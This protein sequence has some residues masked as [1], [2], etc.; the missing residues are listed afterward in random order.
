MELATKV[1]IFAGCQALM[2]FM[3][4][5]AYNNIRLNK[6]AYLVREALVA[7]EDSAWRRLLHSRDDGSLRL[8]T[9]L[10]FAS[11]ERLYADLF[12]FEE[13]ASEL[14]RRN[15]RRSL[16]TL[17]DKLGV[18]LFYIGSRMTESEI[19]M[20]FGVLQCTVSQALRYV[21]P[22]VS[23]R[24]VDNPMARIA[25]PTEA[26]MHDYAEMVMQR[27][28][29]AEDVMGFLD[30]CAMPIHCSW[31][32]NPSYHSDY[33]GT[34][35]VNNVFLFSPAGTILYAAFNYP[36]RWHDSRVATKLV[37]V[38]KAKIGR[39][40]VCVDQGFRRT[41]DLY[42]TFVGPI[43]KKRKRALEPHYRRILVG[44]SNRY[45]R[46]RQA[47][48]W[49]MRVLQGTYTRLKSILPAD[50]EF[51]RLLLHGIL[52]MHNYR[53]NCLGCNQIRTVFDA[54]YERVIQVGN[55]D[56]I[57]RYFLQDDDN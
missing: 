43:S 28:P 31:E 45:V 22:L 50:H 13:I 55:Y 52:L 29:D 9:S 17:K 44:E 40:K 8:L 41:G 6:K 7:V 47:S 3:A 2:L 48:E 42:G 38:V 27:E 25:F 20:L 19:G 10:D 56:R 46:L 18:Y 12:T 37:E 23:E 16:L 33:H 53:T 11:F 57:Q 30:G 36:G 32:D 51:R 26:E 21:V 49:G 35:C 39:Y 54:E 1:S 15:G 34:T 14:A 5:H 24:M 4:I